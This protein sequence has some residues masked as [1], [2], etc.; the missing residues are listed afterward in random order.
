MAAKQNA[1]GKA[2][3]AVILLLIT[4]TISGLVYLRFLQPNVGPAPQI[5]IVSN[6]AMLER[7]RYLANHVMVCMDC[8][9][10]RNF[11]EFAGPMVAGTLGQGGGEFGHAMGFPGTFFAPNITPFNLKNWSDGEIFRT[12]T[13]GVTKLGEP[14]FPVMPYHSYGQVDSCD[15][16]AVIAYLR[17][18]A[19]IDNLV[20][21]SKAD[22]PVSLLVRAEPQTAHLHPKPDSTNRVTYGKYLVTAAGCQDCHTQVNDIGKPIVGLEFAGG[23]QFNIS[24]GSICSSNLTPDENTGL[25]LWTEQTFINRFIQYR[26][27]AIAYRPVA[28]GDFNTVM[29]W[30][31]Y[32]GMKDDDLKAIFAFLKTLRPKQN[33]IRKFR[34]KEAGM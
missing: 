5:H 3:I 24:G 27:S 12:I 33:Q 2:V 29:P 21:V 32:A 16:I 10:T 34:P 20:P 11:D 4:I 28:P 1:P 8:H 17:R 23:R 6:A 30:T 9:S 19:S 31:M 22:F 26:S 13:T 14:I 15:V 18:L 25:G 7:G